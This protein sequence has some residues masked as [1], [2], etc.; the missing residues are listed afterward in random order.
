MN[1]YLKTENASITIEYSNNIINTLL[2]DN[3]DNIGFQRL[4]IE[5]NISELLDVYNEL[6]KYTYNNITIFIKINNYDNKYEEDFNKVNKDYYLII[7]SNID[8]F[9]S[10]KYNNDCFYEITFNYQEKDKIIDIINKYDNI[11]L[12][13]NYDMNDIFNVNNTLEEI[14]KRV[15]K[16]LSFTNLFISKELIYQSP[17]NIYLNNKNSKR[18]YG[19]NNIPRNIYIDSNGNVYSL[20]I[21]NKNIIIGN[22]NDKGIINVLSNCK[23]TKGYKNFIKYNEKLFIDVLDQCPFQT[24]DYIAFLNEVMKYYE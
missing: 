14:V 16:A 9:N 12:N 18:S 17:Y 15:N 2:K 5:C 4:Y 1:K 23:R 21:N 13:I 10:Y 6:N 11:L 24:I 8:K 19:N 20:S 7:C 22:I 3:I